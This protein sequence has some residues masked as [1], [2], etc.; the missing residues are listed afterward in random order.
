M[1]HMGSSTWCDF[2]LCTDVESLIL[3]VPVHRVVRFISFIRYSAL[4]W[5]YK[6]SCRRAMALLSLPF[7]FSGAMVRVS[8]FMVC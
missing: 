1:S 7:V 2:V 3:S 8:M 4:Y 5:L 6:E